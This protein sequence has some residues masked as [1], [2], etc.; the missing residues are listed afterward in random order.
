MRRKIRPH[1]AKSC[2]LRSYNPAHHLGYD[3]YLCSLYINIPEEKAPDTLP[4]SLFQRTFLSFQDGQC[5]IPKEKP[6][7][8]ALT[9]ISFSRN[10]EG[11]SNLEK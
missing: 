11:K 2:A 5:A 4:S 10:L 9:A 1:I 7:A 3:P 8:I 6:K